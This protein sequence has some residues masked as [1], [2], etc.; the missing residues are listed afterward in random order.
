MRKKLI[1]RIALFSTLALAAV[2]LSATPAT[3]TPASP[4]AC[5]MLHTSANG[6]A[7]MFNASP[8]GLGNM[9]ELVLASQAAGCS[10]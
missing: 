5:N 7:G 4:G 9:I 3:A 10:L 6:Y 2:A 1:T 8:Q